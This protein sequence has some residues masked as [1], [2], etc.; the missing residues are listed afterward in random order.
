MPHMT[1]TSAPLVS[2][3]IPVYNGEKFIADAIRSVQ[4]QTYENW[5]LTIGNNCSTDG[6][7]A[8]AE[9]FAARDRRIRVV[10]YPKFVSVVDSHN[11]AFNLISPNAKYGKILGADDLLF[12]TCLEAMVQV[13]EAHPTVGMVVSYVLSG[14]R[15]LGRNYAF[16]DTFVPGR[17]VGRYRFLKDISLF[18]GPSQSMI[19]ADVVRERQPFYN[20]VNYAGDIEAYLE[21][22]Q[23]HDLGFVHQVLTYVRV[24]PESR[25]TSYLSRIEAAE[26]ARMDEI[27]KFGDYYL[28]PEERARCL[29]QATRGYYC[30]LG[31]NIWELRKKEFWDYHLNH[32]TKLGYPPRYSLIAGYALLRLL[33]LVG[34]P[35]R[36]VQGFARRVANRSKSQP[37]RASSHGPTPQSH[38]PIPSKPS[39]SG[40]SMQSMT[41]AR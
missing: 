16:P 23:R 31:R 14:N 22:L 6:T 4:A 21:L 1:S 10:T 2:V 15:V 8:I 5:D 18:S 3:V 28:T 33:D 25:T 32:V 39:G 37:Q 36:T 26:V 34:N 12:P 30:F 38:G 24:G 40:S 19:R 27:T 20:P 9:E 13:A 11:N 41:T 17:E 35:L 29:A 7:V